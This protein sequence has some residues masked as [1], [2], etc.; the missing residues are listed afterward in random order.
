[1]KYVSE[2]KSAN[3]PS[4]AKRLRRSRQPTE[5]MSDL[6][7]QLTRKKFTTIKAPAAPE[8]P[9]APATPAASA[10][11]AES[12]S[13]ATEERRGFKPD[14]EKESTLRKAFD[15]IMAV[16]RRVPQHDWQDD[17]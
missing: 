7:G 9:A 8:A 15:K 16:A 6:L 17:F 4:D 14:P 10:S 5:K 13:L 11:S 1:M 2:S 12:S 3:E